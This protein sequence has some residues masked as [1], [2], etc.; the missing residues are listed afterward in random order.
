M[1]TVDNRN[2]LGDF[3]RR[4]RERLSPTAVGLPEGARRRTPGLRRDEVAHLAN[5]SAVYYERLEQGRGPR[6]S[7]TVL[8]G[9]AEALRMDDEER[10]HLFLLAGYAAPA[11]P[12]RRA[13]IDP[14]LEYVLR[15]VEATTPAFI[16]D[17]LGDV[18]AQNRLNVALFGDFTGLTGRG[19]NLVW[20]W[21]TSPE[22]RHRLEPPEQHAATG[23]A[24][25]A[26]LRGV[27]ARRGHDAAAVALVEQLRGASA[28]FV[29]LWDRQEVSALHC[30]RKV[31]HD[32]RVG[33]LDLDC[34]LLFS[35]ATDQ[36]LLLLKPVPDTPTEARLALL[37]TYS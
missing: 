17:E 27:L 13:G 7:A 21:F 32:E 12:R 2:R 36:R 30:L 4:H 29:R 19:P 23:L 15:S 18:V 24:Y 34:E 25:V 16:A 28:E 31:V 6:P 37:A 10:A 33:R 26:D 1:T 20:R 9:V 35:S 22:W 11:R 8:A 5:M 3:L 14:G